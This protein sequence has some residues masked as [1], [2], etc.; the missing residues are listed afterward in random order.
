M[1]LERALYPWA[2]ADLSWF[3]TS[4]SFALDASLELPGRAMLAHAFVQVA[5]SSF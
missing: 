4:V 3:I 2:P 5:P 1:D